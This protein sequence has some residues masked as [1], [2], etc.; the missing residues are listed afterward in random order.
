MDGGDDISGPREIVPTVEINEQDQ[1][2]TFAEIEKSGHLFRE[3]T[4]PAPN[5]EYIDSVKRIR[6]LTNA[7]KVLMIIGAVAGL[8][9]C[10]AGIVLVSI[11]GSFAP[12]EISLFGISVKTTSIGVASL[13]IGA[14]IVALTI[15]E[16]FKLLNNK[17]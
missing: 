7:A 8:F 14:G 16:V 5:E 6:I 1:P 17:L 12:S 2:V 15:K 4:V 10:V 9:I 13:A 11:S 3:D